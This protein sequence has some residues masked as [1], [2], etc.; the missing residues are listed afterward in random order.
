MQFSTTIIAALFLT[1]TAFATALPQVQED[2]S[3]AIPDLDDSAVNA[4]D[5]DTGISDNEGGVPEFDP[6]ELT[7]DES[8]VKVE[9]RSLYDN[10][11]D[12]DD[13]SHIESRATA[14]SKIVT[15]GRSYKGVKYLWGGCKSKAPFGP[16]KGGM[17]CSCLSRTCV[18]KGTG[19]TI[20]KQNSHT[21][22]PSNLLTPI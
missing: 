1:S 7:G 12:L 13:D 15:C 22:I 14:A 17:D 5:I 11:E 3:L 21:S 20:R 6:L 4:T 9:E 18:K 10:S 8:S 19:T 16:A 2:A